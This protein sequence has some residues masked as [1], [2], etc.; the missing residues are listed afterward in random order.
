M[1][2][3]DPKYFEWAVQFCVQF[4]AGSFCLNV[5]S[6]QHYSIPFLQPRS[7]SP[8]SVPIFR[9]SI[10][11]SFQPF[12]CF[13]MY[14]GYP[15]RIEVRPRI[16]RYCFRWPVCARVVSV[17]GIEGAE[18]RGRVR[19]VVVRELGKWKKFRPIVL[20][21]VAILSEVGFQ[22]LVYVLCLSV[23]LEVEGCR[24]PWFDSQEFHDIPPEL[25]SECHVPVL[26][27][28]SQII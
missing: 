3:T 12:S 24:H 26:H 1:V 7:F 2:R 28:T 15:A 8:G 21:V 11:R 14:R 23:G 22:H 20:L 6:V 17:I 5:S 25:R 10:L 18:V 16:S 9:H 27:L 19:G 13:I 4:S